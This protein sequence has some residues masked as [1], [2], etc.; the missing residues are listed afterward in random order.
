ME[1][2]PFWKL[3]QY[4][5]NYEVVLQDFKE[6]YTIPTPVWTLN[7]VLLFFHV[8]HSKIPEVSLHMCTAQFW[9]EGDLPAS[10]QSLLF[11]VSAI[12]DALPGSWKLWFSQ[13]PISTWASPPW[14]TTR[15]FPPGLKLDVCG[16]VVGS[17]QLFSISPDHC[18]LFLKVY[19][20]F[21][22]FVW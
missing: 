18:L 13:T 8:V 5:L 22:P 21:I 16:G 1:I 9:T 19:S 11:T 12:S 2:N 10:L 6:I 7:I 20:F 17:P 14:D 3:F 15:K 4:S